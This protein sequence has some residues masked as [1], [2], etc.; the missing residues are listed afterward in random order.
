MA[1]SSEERRELLRVARQALESYLGHAE[2]PA[3][4][5]S[6]PALHEK[7]GAFVTLEKEG[8]LRGCIGHMAEDKPLYL[9]VQEMAV[10]AAT[11]DPRFPAVRIDELP[12]IEIEISVLSP[13]R[14]VAD[15]S[16][17]R[18]GEHGIV[19]SQGWRRGV[20]LPQV[21]LREGWDREKFLGYACLKA[22][23]PFESWKSGD[24]EI[25]IFTAEVFG[26]K[27]VPG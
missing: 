7:A 13:L 18:V 21:P 17:I 23:L 16:E 4:L 1:L 8:E 24:V 27:D 12:A 22:G 20:L 11:G 10:Q 25:Q 26:E 9:A 15:A 6:D 2:L 3:I 5:P 14:V 19:V